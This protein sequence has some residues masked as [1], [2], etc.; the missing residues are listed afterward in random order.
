M[1]ERLHF[2]F[3]NGNPPQCSCLENTAGSVIRRISLGHAGSV[4]CDAYPWDTHHKRV[5]P[6]DGG[7]WWAAVYGVAQSQ[8]RLKWLSSSSSCSL[9]SKFLVEF[10][11]EAVWSWLLFAGRFLITVLISVLVIGLLR[12]YISSWFSFGKLYFCKNLSIS[13]KLS[14]LFAYSADSSF[15]WSFVFLCCL[16]WF[17]HFHF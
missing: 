9:F 14:I 4:I 8:T 16:L 12:F 17:L 5:C 2:D 3:S 13:S 11:C 7:A 6:R 10:S 15:L 1:T